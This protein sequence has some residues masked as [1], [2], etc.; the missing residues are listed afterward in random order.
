VRKVSGVE[1]RVGRRKT[2]R[3]EEKRCSGGRRGK[4]IRVK[5]IK[6]RK[7]KEEDVG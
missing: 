6:E 7:E 3:S 1:K 2:G 5:W 4:E